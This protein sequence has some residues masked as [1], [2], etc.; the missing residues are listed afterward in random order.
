MIIGVMISIT[1]WT[2]AMMVETVVD[3]TLPQITAFFVHALTQIIAGVEQLAHQLL[4]LDQ[5]LP[6]QLCQQLMTQVIMNQHCWCF[7]FALGSNFKKWQDRESKDS[8]VSKKTCSINNTKL[9][10]S[11]SK[12]GNLFLN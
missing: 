7:D 2:A 3:V 1:T 9:F 6:P 12:L 4:Q 8:I 10:C 11:I 5:L